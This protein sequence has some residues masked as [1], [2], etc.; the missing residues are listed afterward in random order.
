MLA[1]EETVAQK[2]KAL[3]FACCDYSVDIDIA[4]LGK[5]R[6]AKKEFEGVYKRD[7]SF[8]GKVFQYVPG[9]SVA[10]MEAANEREKEMEDLV[11]ML[12]DCLVKFPQLDHIAF[13]PVR[14]RRIYATLKTRKN[15]EHMQRSWSYFGVKSIGLHVLLSA[16]GRSSVKPARLSMVV[17]QDV[18]QDESVFGFSSLTSLEGFKQ[19]CEKTKV[20]DLQVEGRF[21][22][23][24]AFLDID[25]LVSVRITTDNFPALRHLSYKCTYSRPLDP[26]SIPNPTLLMLSSMEALWALPTE[27][28]QGVASDLAALRGDSD[29]SSWEETVRT[30]VTNVGCQNQAQVNSGPSLALSAQQLSHYLGEF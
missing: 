18:D 12:V 20:L 14:Y 29:D 9:L 24:T 26:L 25:L 30:W 6:R 28:L 11:Q 13:I 19:V 3:G 8:Y 21:F 2:V 7:I 15:F 27:V 4:E 22:G 10:N 5:N 16:L 17:D 23:H 1:N